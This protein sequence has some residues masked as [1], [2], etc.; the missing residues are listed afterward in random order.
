[1]VAPTLSTLRREIVSP[2]TLN[3]AS[4]LSTTSL[5]VNPAPR[6]GSAFWLSFLAI[7]VSMFLSALDLSAIPTALPT[8]TDDL[9]GGDKFIWVGSA[10]GLASA[11]VLLLAGRLADIFGRK[12]VML[13][14]I[15]LFT[16]GSV[17]A[18]ISN[19]MDMLIGARVV[20]GMGGGSIIT[21]AE[22]IMADLVPLAERGVYQGFI[23]LVW[24]LAAGV[25]P[26]IGA[27]L[28][29]KASWRWL[30]YLNLPLTGIA[31]ALVSIFLRVRSPPGS[32]REK[33][34][35]VDWIGNMLM[36]AGSTLALLG[37]TWGGVSYPWDSAHVAVPLVIGLFLI[38]LFVVYEVCIPVEPTFPL[39]VVANRTSASAYLATFVHGITSMSAIYYLP[40]YFQASLGASPL[41]SSVQ[42]LP[43]ALVIAP[44]A[45]FCGII[46]KVINK[47]RAVNVVGWIISIIGFGLLS[48]LRADSPTSQWVGFQFLMAAGSGIVYAS[49]IFAILAPLPVSRNAAALA[50]YTFSRTFAQTWGIAISG[51]ILQNQ[52]KNRLPAAF[53]SQFPAGADISYQ[54]IPLIAS[55]EEPLR[56]EVRAAFALS[57]AVIWKVMV[58]LCGVGILT[59]FLL[60]EVPMVKHTDETYGLKETS[61]TNILR[62]V[63]KA[64]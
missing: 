28:A 2:L 4:T 12:P 33:L 60:K 36:A 17:L 64:G 7:L 59:L 52:L 30:F 47:Y 18:G 46:V 11:A 62:D 35:R 14:S 5:G 10:Y 50:F 61:T 29:Q 15:A 44:F 54:A 27:V 24:A 51:T 39:Q 45:L 56:S 38:G 23:V 16:L 13:T 37:L 6:K 25:G 48:L 34:A 31:F 19:S 63:E 40:V 32:V 55:L 43:T 26:V 22:I 1:M 53:T 3:E 20:Q 57:M 41:R 9:N 8:I 58:G 21:M 42:T 49:T